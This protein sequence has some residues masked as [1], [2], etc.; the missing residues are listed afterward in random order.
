VKH[1]PTGLILTQ[2]GTTN[3]LCDHL[4]SSNGQVLSPFV[5]CSQLHYTYQFILIMFIIIKC[6]KTSCLFPQHLTQWRHT[7]LKIMHLFCLR[8]PFLW[9]FVYRKQ[10]EN[11]LGISNST[12]S[13]WIIQGELSFIKISLLSTWRVDKRTE[14]HNL[15]P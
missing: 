7:V 1:Q 14:L 4:A 3:C 9:T 15:T 2:G 12:V 8:I 11:P 10:Q 13:W 5:P 6:I